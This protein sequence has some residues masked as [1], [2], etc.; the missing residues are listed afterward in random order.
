[1][2]V[3][4]C[5]R[6]GGQQRGLISTAISKPAS[7]LTAFSSLDDT[8]TTHAH[9]HVHAHHVHAHVHVTCDRFFF[10]IICINFE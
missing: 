5:D 3:S 7:C 10:C 1:M 8:T 4:V 2:C 9:A 6:I